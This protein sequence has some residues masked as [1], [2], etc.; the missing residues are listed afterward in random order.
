MAIVKNITN[1][2]CID[3]IDNAL[4]SKKILV[5]CVPAASR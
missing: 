2:S 4:I 3:S 5:H 1:H